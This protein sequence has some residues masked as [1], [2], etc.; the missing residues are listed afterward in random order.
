MVHPFVKHVRVADSR[1]RWLSDA[2][3]QGEPAIVA[4]PYAAAIHDY[5]T[6]A[7]APLAAAT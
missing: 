6:E 4:Y 3:A 1:D 2:Y 7:P 5:L